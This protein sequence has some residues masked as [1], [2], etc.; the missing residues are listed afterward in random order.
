MTIIM[1]LH[2]ELCGV[3]KIGSPGLSLARMMECIQRAKSKINK[4][5]VLLKKELAHADEVAKQKLIVYANEQRLHMKDTMQLMMSA[6]LKPG[7][8]GGTDFGDRTRQVVETLPGLPGG[9]VRG[10]GGGGGRGSKRKTNDGQ[11][12]ATGGIGGMGTA[13]EEVAT[14]VPLFQ[15]GV[16]RLGKNANHR[17]EEEEEEEGV[18]SLSVALV[19]GQASSGA[20]SGASSSASS[21]ATL[22]EEQ[23][24]EFESMV[25]QIQSNALN[26]TTPAS[27][28]AEDHQGGISSLSEAVAGKAKARLEKKKTKKKKKRNR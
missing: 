1:N 12:R 25:A 18:S 17:G 10:G 2:G 4:L 13:T 11:T 14:D 23:V 5:S 24:E 20:S 7:E 22:E 19:Q 9:A 15:G 21:S 6:P 3:H 16:T 26:Q 8:R 27:V 28:V